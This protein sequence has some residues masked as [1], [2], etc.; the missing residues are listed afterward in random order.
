[1]IGPLA[2]RIRLPWSGRSYREF[3]RVLS[4]EKPDVAHFHNVFPSLTVSVYDACRDAGVPVVQTLHNFR[5]LVRGRTFF[6]DG[7][8]CD[9]CV[10]FGPRRASDYACYRGSR[11]AT[12]AVVRMQER[13][14]RDRV[15][16]T[17]VDRFHRADPVSRGKKSWAWDFPRTRSSSTEFR[18]GPKIRRTTPGDRALFL[19][20]L[21]PEKGARTA[22]EGF[23]GMKGRR[24]DVAGDGPGGGSLRRGGR[25]G[26]YRLPRARRTGAG[27]RSSWPPARSS[28]SP[29]C[30]SRC[31][32]WCC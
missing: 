9:E 15:W 21:S 26:E 25:D 30:G 16:Q 22:V 29:P 27:G 7:R 12:A 31:C 24:L 10:T 6:R 3:A 19:G 18:A 11:L 2:T 20:R 23:L 8:A 5:I 28:S 32:R 4:R 1:V 17:R 13:H 14:N